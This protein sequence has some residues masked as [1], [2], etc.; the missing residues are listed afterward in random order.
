MW[1][2]LVEIS[3]ANPS[4][5]K[6][7]PEY[8]S[9]IYCEHISRPTNAGEIL[10]FTTEQRENV[11]DLNTIKYLA[12]IIYCKDTR[13]NENFRYLEPNRFSEGSSLSY[14]NGDNSN[15]CPSTII[16][17]SSVQDGAMQNV[18]FPCT[19]TSQDLSKNLSSQFYIQHFANLTKPAEVRLTYFPETTCDNFTLTVINYVKWFQN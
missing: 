9:K 12:C 17:E 19:L 10:G 16:L 5:T 13:F 4:R 2:H 8:F 18:N 15:S 14:V 11:M 1:E 3:T 6:L 7:P